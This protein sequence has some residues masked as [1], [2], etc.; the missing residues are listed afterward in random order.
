MDKKEKVRKIVSQ[1]NI[2]DDTFFQKMAEDIGF[3]EE[4]ISTILEQKVIVKEVVP[5]NS[6]KNLQGR[7]VILDA[8]CTLGNGKECN[9]EVQN[10]QQMQLR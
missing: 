1:L 6:I 7:S 3:C 10:T 4:L 9:V 5:Q 8:L 2:I